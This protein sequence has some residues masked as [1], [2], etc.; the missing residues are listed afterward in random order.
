[1]KKALLII[2]IFLGGSNLHAQNNKIEIGVGGY[3]F[4]PNDYYH[5]LY[6]PIIDNFNINYSRMIL[7]NTHM[8]VNYLNT[9]IISDILLIANQLKE[10]NDGELLTR[11]K[12]HYADLGIGYQVFKF[13]NHILTINGALSIAHGT[14]TYQLHFERTDYAPIISIDNQ[15]ETYFG[16]LIGLKYDYLFW[17]D[18]FNIGL[19]FSARKYLNKNNAHLEIQD[20]HIQHIDPNIP[21]GRHSFPFQI[22]Y[23]IH[24]GVNF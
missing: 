10:G 16:G 13:K 8:Y 6:A 23:G 20:P 3:K 7:K 24:L 14:N 11:Y 15:K 12:Y 17:K 4:Y 18:R 22:N 21:G 1:M 9:S 5:L 19:N 2:L